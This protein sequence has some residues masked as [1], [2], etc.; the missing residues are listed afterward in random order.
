MY[1]FHNL[2]HDFEDVIKDSSIKNEVQNMVIISLKID[3]AMLQNW[4][5]WWKQQFERYRSSRS[6]M[7]F[8]IGVLKKFRKF[9]RTAPNLESV[10]N[11][12]ASLKASCEIWKIFKNIFF[13]RTFPVVASEDISIKQ[14]SKEKIFESWEATV[15]RSS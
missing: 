3:T 5:H 1:L 7:F 2:Q 6:W 4:K 15:Q 10:F 9:Q 11:K 12:V 13:Y 14:F 8:K